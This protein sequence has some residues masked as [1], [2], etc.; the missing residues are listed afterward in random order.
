M[1]SISDKGKIMEMIFHWRQF[2]TKRT[3]KKY[4]NGP[5]QGWLTM[6]MRESM[7]DKSLLFLEKAMENA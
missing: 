5:S 6:M 2:K 7:L 3:R 4:D 1:L